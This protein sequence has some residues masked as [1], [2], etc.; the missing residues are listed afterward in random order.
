MGTLR[1]EIESNTGLQNVAELRWRKPA[2]KHVEDIRYISNRG[3][4]TKLRHKLKEHGCLLISMLAH[5][6]NNS[7]CATGARVDAYFAVRCTVPVLPA[8]VLMLPAHCELILMSCQDASC[9]W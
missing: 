2:S 6:L 8:S 7:I 1:W 9:G 3:L 4:G 5:D